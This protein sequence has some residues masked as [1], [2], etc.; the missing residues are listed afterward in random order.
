MKNPTRFAHCAKHKPIPMNSYRSLCCANLFA[1]FF[2]LCVDNEI[3][4][5][6]RKSPF[7]ACYVIVMVWCPALVTLPRLQTSGHALTPSIFTVLTLIYDKAGSFLGLFFIPALLSISPKEEIGAVN[8][9]Q[10]PPNSLSKSWLQLILIR[11]GMRKE[12]YSFIEK[13]NETRCEKI[14]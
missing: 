10:K 2:L 7:L 8:I 14:P 4:F 13:Q 5:T 6:R 12:N 9:F 3:N 11:F 1:P